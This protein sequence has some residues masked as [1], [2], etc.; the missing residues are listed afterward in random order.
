MSV[1]LAISPCP[2]DTFIFNRFQEPDYFSQKI[3]LHMEDV[4]ELNR[5]A[6]EE[7][8]HQV[9]KL[10]FFA[11]FA[12]ENRGLYRMLASGG[13]LGR[14]CGPLLLSNA[15]NSLQNLLAAPSGTILVPGKW[16]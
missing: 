3:H 7:Q 15:K 4:E 10:S 11:M 12:L 1:D 13:A 5:R 8:R 9:T 2:N 16:T 6:I 14:G